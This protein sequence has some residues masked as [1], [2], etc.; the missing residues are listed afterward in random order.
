[1]SVDAAEAL[2]QA[3]ALRNAALCSPVRQVRYELG[4]QADEWDRAA[5]LVVSADSEATIELLGA[6]CPG[7]R[8][9]IGEAGYAKVIRKTSG[10]TTLHVED[11][12][13]P[14]GRYW[15]FHSDR[16]PVV[17]RL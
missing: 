14:R 7:M 16:S 11:E 8:V 3:E 13:D 4:A 9:F 15:N 10:G 5:N 1:M 2:D 6:V 12:F 17:V